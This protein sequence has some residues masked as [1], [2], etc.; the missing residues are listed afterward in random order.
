MKQLVIASTLL[1]TACMTSATGINDCP[2]R[3]TD[4]LHEDGT[5]HVEASLTDES[6]EK[7]I[8]TDQK[9]IKRV[10]TNSPGGEV[11][12]AV[13]YG[14]LINMLD[15]PT[16]VPFGATCASACI[17]L[18]I[19]GNDESEMLGWVGIHSMSIKNK[20]KK[21]W[22]LDNWTTITRGYSGAKKYLERFG[23]DGETLIRDMKAVSSSGMRWLTAGELESYKK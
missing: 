10:V 9:L 20:K 16:V 21:D 23:Y 14:T 3:G 5:Y 1:L 7:F 19:A 8:Q 22:T 13:A 18:Y 4:H 2:D 11:A 12:V 17:Y 6:L 15:V